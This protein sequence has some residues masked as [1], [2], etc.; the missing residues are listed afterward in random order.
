LIKIELNLGFYLRFTILRIE[1]TFKLS[2]AVHGM[3][4]ISAYMILCYFNGRSFRAMHYM[5]H[6]CVSP[7][8]VCHLCMC[9]TCAYVSPVHKCHLCIC[10]TCAYVSP[11]HK[12]HLCI[13]VTCAYVSLVHMCHLCIRVTCAY[14]SPVHACHLCI[15]VTCAYFGHAVIGHDK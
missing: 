3:N 13:S 6:L 12:C 1:F 5:I 15:R 7:V 2:R 9:V 14:V 4:L 8:H 10:V 11:V